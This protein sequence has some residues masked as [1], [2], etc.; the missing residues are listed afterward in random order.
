[1]LIAAAGRAPARERSAAVRIEIGVDPAARIRATAGFQDQL[2]VPIGRVIVE[3]RA[4]ESQV[5]TECPEA[6]VER[7]VA[8]QNS[9]GR[10]AAIRNV[11]GGDC[12]VERKSQVRNSL[13]AAI[14]VILVEE[15]DVSNVD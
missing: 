13:R 14:V 9:A 5:V 15:L 11:L 2:K 8:E 4:I 12:Q 7:I 6:A 3:R 1:S 10:N